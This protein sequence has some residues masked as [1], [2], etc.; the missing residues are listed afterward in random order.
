MES[1]NGFPND[2]F[3]ENLMNHFDVPKSILNIYICE[4][5]MY[6]YFLV[7]FSAN[8][9]KEHFNEFMN[10]VNDKLESLGFSDL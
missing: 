5:Y 6:L 4:A 10:F 7:I 2:F 9:L 8:I 1:L 3:F